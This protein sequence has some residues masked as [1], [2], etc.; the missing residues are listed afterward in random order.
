VIAA[1]HLPAAATVP[2]ALALLAVVGWYWTRLGAAG[3]PPVR[4]RLRRASPACA[5]AGLPAVAAGFSIV[6]PDVRPVP[7]AIVW[8]IA[9]AALLA[10]VALAV[11]DTLACVGEY[12]RETERLLAT[13]PPRGG[14]R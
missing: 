8:T 6:D 12:R 2:L 1:T 11:V 14:R 13:R 3:V 4:R 5:L 7:Y 10:V 9:L